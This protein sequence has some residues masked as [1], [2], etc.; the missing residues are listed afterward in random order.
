M[1]GNRNVVRAVRTTVIAAALV[2]VGGARDAIAQPFGADGNGRAGVRATS[3]VVTR[4]QVFGHPEFGT[5]Y[6][7]VEAL[8][9]VWLAP[10]AAESSPIATPR[11]V[12]RPDIMRS[13]PGEDGGIQVYF[14]G[15]RL[16]GVDRLRDIPSRL[17][18]TIRHLSGVEASARFGLGHAH[19]AI[20]VATSSAFDE[21]P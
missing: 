2:S 7:V 10:R 12:R 19:G 17:V 1:R 15:H 20:L 13:A 18:Y 16:G 8:H 3:S 9:G 21:R 5:A 6:A 4:A 14:D 11:S